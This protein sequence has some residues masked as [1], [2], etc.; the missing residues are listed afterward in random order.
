MRGMELMGYLSNSG[1]LNSILFNKQKRMFK[2]ETHFSQHFETMKSEGN[3]TL[4]LTLLE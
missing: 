1:T 3:C 4:D 2:Y